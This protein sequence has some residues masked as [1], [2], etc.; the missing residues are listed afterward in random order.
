MGP[1]S[2]GIC[3]LTRAD[4]ERREVRP[5][6]LRGA[7]IELKIGRQKDRGAGDSIGA[8]F[9]SRFEGAPLEAG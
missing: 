6:N 5:K 1:M 7:L 2:Q 8:E 3:K 9:A 4:E